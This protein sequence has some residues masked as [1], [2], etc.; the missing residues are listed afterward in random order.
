MRSV[1]FKRKV[2]FAKSVLFVTFIF[3]VQVLY[4]GNE[5]QG[6][7]TN[8]SG[9]D[10]KAWVVS[11]SSEIGTYPRVGTPEYMTDKAYY[12][13]GLTMREN[14]ENKQNF[15]DIVKQAW[16][17]DIPC[18]SDNL[19]K[20][21][22][23]KA[24]LVFIDNKRKE[25][26]ERCLA[27]AYRINEYAK[28]YY[29]RSRPW[30]TFWGDGYIEDKGNTLYKGM[31]G[32]VTMWQH[33]YG[34]AENQ[35]RSYPSG[36]S[37]TTYVAALCLCTFYPEKASDIL[38]AANNFTMSR[39]ILGIHHKSDIDAAYRLARCIFE[40]IKNSTSYQEA[41]KDLVLEKYDIPTSNETENC[42]NDELK[43]VALT[44]GVSADLKSDVNQ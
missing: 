44:L 21:F 25:N 26:L 40:E 10:A 43:N 30:F 35:F 17:N 37:T 7:F 18:N 9:F 28:S 32:N 29:H 39:V 41:I 22:S 27:D 2:N 6:F 11:K 5:N 12:E 4:A 23:E 24:G 19:V 34:N 1:I 13:A 36:H 38:K 3:L 14:K 15:Q 20:Y 42:F 31:N 33:V 8:E 16:N